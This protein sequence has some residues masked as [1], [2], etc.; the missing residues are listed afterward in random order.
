[1]RQVLVFCARRRRLAAGSRGN[2]AAVGTGARMPQEGADAV[3]GVRREDVLEL[4]GLLLDLGLVLHVQGLGE[5]ALRQAVAADD[6][7]GALPAARGELDDQV[8]VG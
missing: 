2:S 1:M 7:G 8:A 4:A 5:E 3:G 6:V